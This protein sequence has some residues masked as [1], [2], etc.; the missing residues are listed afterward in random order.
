VEL[1]CFDDGG[2]VPAEGVDPA[3]RVVPFRTEAELAE[4]LRGGDAE[5][6]YS[7]YTFDHRLTRRGKA[8]FSVAD[9]APG[10][11]GA[12]DTLRRLVRRCGLPFYRA[13]GA[14]LED[15]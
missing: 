8:A 11:S 7:E 4:A 10:P 13:Y 9:F 12:V 6:V 3:W 1:L 2:G 15:P 5:A 14:L